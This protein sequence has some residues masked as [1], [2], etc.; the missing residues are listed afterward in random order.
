MW[1]TGGEKKAGGSAMKNA[2]ADDDIRVSRQ[3]GPE[4]FEADKWR[5][6]AFIGKAPVIRSGWGGISPSEQNRRSGRAC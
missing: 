1:Y 3:E 6:H 4:I 5:F 2:A